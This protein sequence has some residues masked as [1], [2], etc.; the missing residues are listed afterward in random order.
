MDA[1]V[2]IRTQS[3]RQHDHAHI[4]AAQENSQF[5]MQKRTIDYTCTAHETMANNQERSIDCTHETMDGVIMHIITHAQHAERHYTES[6]SK[7]E[8]ISTLPHDPKPV[9]RGA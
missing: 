4:D 5:D 3:L 6:V 9:G 7:T 1:S 2:T 8:H